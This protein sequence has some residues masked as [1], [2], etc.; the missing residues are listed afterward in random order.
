M[1]NSDSSRN[2]RGLI[3]ICVALFALALA[4]YIT[5]ARNLIRSHPT[6]TSVSIVNHSSRAVRNVYS[7]HLNAD[8]WSADLLGDSE[9]QAGQSGS[10]D[11][12]CDDTQLKVIAEDQDGCFET[13]AVNC[14]TSSTWT[15]T[16]D[17]ARDCGQP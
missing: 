11:V 17:T 15:I 3:I 8:D 7:S 10:V 14:G 2:P 13:Q 12:P 6:A 9:I 16:D 1:K 4:P 5:R